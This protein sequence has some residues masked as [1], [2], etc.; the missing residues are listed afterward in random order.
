MLSLIHIFVIGLIFLVSRLSFIEINYEKVDMDRLHVTD[1]ALLNRYN[2]AMVAYICLLYT[3]R[4][5]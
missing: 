4:C 1:P 2:N 5:V 3:S